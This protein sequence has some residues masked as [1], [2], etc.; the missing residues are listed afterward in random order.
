[1][2]EPQPIVEELIALLKARPDLEA[3]LMASNRKADCAARATVPNAFGGVSSV[4]KVAR[5][6]EAAH[7]AEA[8]NISLKITN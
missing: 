6:P 1:M 2:T 7:L 3:A 5:S 4:L 8:E